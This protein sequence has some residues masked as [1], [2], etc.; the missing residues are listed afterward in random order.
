MTV[1]ALS[2]LNV[3][4][5][6]EQ[7]TLRSL[8]ATLDNAQEH[9]QRKNAAYEGKRLIA[10]LGI[11][12][13]P[14]F[15]SIETVI[16]WPGLTVDVLSER[17]GFEGITSISSPADDAEY[18][19]VIDANRLMVKADMANLDALIYGVC[20]LAVGTGGPGEPD[21]LVTVEPPTRM[22]GLYS[23]R[24]GQLT[25]AGRFYVE[26]GVSYATLYVPDETVTCHGERGKWVVDNRDYHGLG[27]VPVTALVNRPRDDS[28][29]GGSEI[30]RAVL[31]Y[32]DA[33]V[34]TML[35][36]EVG[37]EFYATP[38]RYIL[39]ADESAF[40]DAAGNKKSAWET[41]IGRV[42]ALTRDEEGNLPQVGQFAAA[43]PAPYLDMLRGY[44]QMLAAEAAVPASYLGFVT[45]NPAS[46][47]AIRQSEARLVKRAQQRTA[48]FE[49]GYVEMM[50][51][52][53]LV[54]DGAG[55]APRAKMSVRWTEPGTPT[56]AAQADA[57]VKLVGAG[58]LPATGDV[59]WELLGIPETT[60]RRL[61]ADVRAAGSTAA[62]TQVASAA[63]QARQDP[64]VAALAARGV[65]TILPGA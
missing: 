30:T 37:R 50:H 63:Q 2:V 48:Q 31:A 6:G 20:F 44:A 21:P 23:T 54:R 3:L 19:E 64:Q 52:A 25:A 59:T 46:A 13:P 38:Q 33:A 4:S 1:P 22:T 7:E 56:R 16:G 27:R 53:M 57:V 60:R 10:S 17:L 45:D 47:D 62:L 35:A 11:A 34:R 14:Q 39:G 58:I 36:M 55:S 65:R 5:E 8:R 42:L 12:I 9:N 28:L 18:A 51:L 15:A 24:A 32:T 40:Q 61:A 43:S 26:A 41:Y 49:R 29:R